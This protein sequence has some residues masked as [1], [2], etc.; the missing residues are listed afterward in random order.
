MSFRRKL[1]FSVLGL[2]LAG[3]GAMLLVFPSGCTEM[4]PVNGQLDVT[5][6]R[7]QRIMALAAEEAAAIPDPDTRLT[8]QL[9]LADTQIQRGWPVDAR[10]TLT[11]A[12]DTL[13]A[14]DAV[15]LNDHA[16]ISGWIS[17]SQLARQ[18]DDLALAVGACDSAKAAMT[19][20]EDPAKRCQYVMGI[21]NELQYL[22]GKPAAA[23]LLAL[24]APWTRVIDNLPKRREATVAFASAL[25]TLDDF[26]DAKAMIHQDDDAAWR[27]Q[28]LQMLASLRPA[29]QGPDMVGAASLRVDSP[30]AG[31][32]YFG[33]NL[34]YQQIFQNQTNSQTGKD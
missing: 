28:T 17:I 15:K 22:K 1:W 6:D 4:H 25:F 27:S 19:A 33:K 9:N 13:Q 5:N 7:S 16:R 21:S 8:R 18:A 30:Q 26:T 11:A 10:V 12:R 2:V 14:K 20:I 29:S 34:N 23:A 3:G 24:A 32:F 31:S